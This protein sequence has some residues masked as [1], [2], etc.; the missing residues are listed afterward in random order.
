MFKGPFVIAWG[1]GLVVVV[2]RRIRDK[3]RPGMAQNRRCPVHLL[4]VNAGR[5]LL[6]VDPCD[7]AVSSQS[8]VDVL[9][10]QWLPEAQDNLA[11]KD[12]AGRFVLVAA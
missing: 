5:S 2:I 4:C 11:L 1:Q 8:E 7:S 9:D 6:A 3:G 12:L 10:L